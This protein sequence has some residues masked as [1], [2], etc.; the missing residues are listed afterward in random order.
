MAKVLVTL[1]V[2]AGVTPV[3]HAAPACWQE[4]CGKYPPAHQA[5]E[6]SSAHVSYGA[7][8]KLK[9]ASDKDGNRVPD[10]SYVGYHYG[11]RPLPSVPDVVTISP[12][13]GDNTAHV[14]QALD[15]VGARTPDANGHRGAVK[16]AAG[17]YEIRGIVRIRQSG[18]V[19]RGS[20]DATTLYGRGDAP[21]QRTIVVLGSDSKT[22]WTTGSATEVTTPFVQVGSLS[23]EVVD[24]TRFK[25]GQ[26]VMVKHPSSQKWIDAVGGGG[27]VN[28]PK[29][30]AGS[31]DLNWVRRIKAID[32]RTLTFD[33]PIYNHLDRSLAVST[34]APVTARNL[35]TE[36][37][38]ESLR[39]DVETKGGEDENHAWNAI[40][41]FGADDSWVRSVKTRYFGYAGVVTERSVRITVKDSQATDPV[42]IRTGGRMYNFA[43][44]GNSHLILFTGVHASKARHAFVSNGANSVAG[45]VWTRSTV[46]GGDAEAH[47]RWSQGLL[48]DN[49]HVVS[50]SGQAKLM[51][52][53]D[54]GT[55]HGWGAAHSVIW[56]YNKEMVVQK[57]PTAQNYA[58]S[59]EGTRRSQPYFPGP[60]G[61]I[62]IK[63]GPLVPESLYEAQVVDRLAT[64]STSGTRG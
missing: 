14:Q 49:I 42:A 11:E 18:V 13:A 7:N 16:L 10:F 29:W 62:E 22:P 8:G 31:M 53:G 25:A 59:N 4:F 3:A 58:V 47:R 21:H 52:R 50:S 28:S 24:P 34:V 32:G 36:S 19:L 57:P 27:T 20:G 15:Q 38:V 39:V 46:D 2:L 12:V 6:W 9:Y 35:V 5:G 60:W 17:K 56:D 44:N 48:F 26:E 30:T 37:G 51:N 43:A 23:L 54:Y 63:T 41:V 64:T 55:S 33:A 40:G 61:S 1:V 45:V